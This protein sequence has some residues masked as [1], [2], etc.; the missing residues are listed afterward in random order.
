MSH[1]LYLYNL[2]SETGAMTS[3]I[4]EWK[5]VIPTL[6]IPLLAH[7]KAK[8]KS[9][10][11]NKKIGI[12]HLEQFYQL[13]EKELNLYQHSKFQTNKKKV[14][15]YLNDL[16]YDVFYM[17][18]TDVFNMSEVPKK[19]Q[20]QDMV[21]KLILQQS[22]FQLAIELSSLAPLEAILKDTNYHRNW[23]ELIEHEYVDFGW[24][25]L[26]ISHLNHPEVY[27]FENDQKF[28]LLNSKQQEILKAE[29]DQIQPFS[30]AGYAI[31]EQN[32]Q[33][34]VV[35]AN[36][37]IVIPV[38]WDEIQNIYDYEKKYAIVSQNQKVGLVDLDDSSI[39][40]LPQYEYIEVLY[41]QFIQ[42]QMDGFYS[43]LDENFKPI[44]QNSKISFELWSEN[45]LFSQHSKSIYKT[46]YYK[47]GQ[48]LGELLEDYLIELK[49]HY[50]LIR[51]IKKK[52]KF[53]KLM[54][55]KGEIIFQNIEDI[56]YNTDTDYIALKENSIWFFYDLLQQKI[57]KNNDIS[58]V[59]KE[60]FHYFTTLKNSFIISNAEHHFSLFNPVTEQFL[61][62]FDLKIQGIKVIQ[63]HQILILKN[64]W[65]YQ[66]Y[67]LDKNILS[68][69]IF[70]YLSS[71]INH[72]NIL[73]AYRENNLF[74][75][76]QNF[77]TEQCSFEQISQIYMERHK[78]YDEDLEK[79]EWFCDQL[80]QKN[81]DLFYSHFQNDDL[82]K[83]GTTSYNNQKIADAVTIYKIGV[84]RGHAQMMAELAY[85]YSKEE[86]FL[87]LDLAIE[88]YQKAVAANNA[89]AQNNLGFHY[90][91][92]T[93]IKKNIKKGIFLY[94][95]SAE[96]DYGLALQNLAL[97]Y[98]SGEEIKQNYELAL[99]YFKRSEKNFYF[100]YPEI[101]EIYYQLGDYK[102]AFKYLKKNKDEDFTYIYLG[103]FYHKGYE[104]KIDLNKAKKYYEK[105]IL[106]G[107]YSYAYQALLEFYMHDGIF[108]SEPDYQRILELALHQKIDLPKHVLPHKK[109]KG[110]F[111][112]FLGRKDK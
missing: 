26:E 17:D 19:Q 82:V 41:N 23:L 90:I 9:L 105:A 111:S 78:L 38:Q 110:F 75:I 102:N 48:C 20:A 1:R 8:G 109:Q 57:I 25:L 83:L 66:F 3:Y 99:D 81:T 55:K 30:F 96:Q 5:Y 52:E 86:Q 85:I 46:F 68:T 65:S 53:F 108:T 2:C 60:F 6:F 73:L 63:A 98:F 15:E 101:I 50:L 71:H 45:F 24:Y 54:N 13:L 97:Q 49:H 4:G 40:L 95:K 35:Y 22:S 70:D 21:E 93:G 87:N 32:N 91:T 107:K 77:K 28:G 69:E 112:Q 39:R 31:I 80:K 56:N 64:K 34:G 10:Y 84:Q 42:I 37:E 76:N 103:I 74:N 92:G 89:M 62:P 7:P 67:N 47:D 94:Q 106:S 88:L 18:A 58:K 61:I 43:I 16:P 51:P 36:G 14:L 12:Q 11:F 59:N 100:N 33:F 72:C 44:I 27:I 79:F 104:L 29:F